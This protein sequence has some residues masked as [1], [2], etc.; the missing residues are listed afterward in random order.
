MGP[1]P[2]LP[3]TL[4]ALPLTLLALPL[5]YLI[6]GVL[7]LLLL[8]R[9]RRRPLLLVL[10]AQCLDQCLLGLPHR[11]PLLDSDVAQPRR[12]YAVQRIPPWRGRV[13][14]CICTRR[15]ACTR[16]AAAQAFRV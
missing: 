16:G 14:E 10:P 9:R 2:A 1:L 4:P 12:Q 7:L 15:E 13:A 3:L 11:L 6:R 5:I 8:L